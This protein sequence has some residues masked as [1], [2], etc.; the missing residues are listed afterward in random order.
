[1][2]LSVIIPTYNEEAYIQRVLASVCQEAHDPPEVIVV[3]CGS[4]DHT[5]T[6]AR[7]YPVT[8]VQ[9]ASLRGC[10]WKSLNCG[11][12]IARGDVLLFLDADS[13]VP[14]HFD[15]IIQRSL[16]RPNVVGGAFELAFDEGGISLGIILLIN[17]IRYRFRKRFYG[18]QGI[19]I[20]SSVFVKMGGWPALDIMEAAYFCKRAQTFGKLRLIT[21]PLTT[22]ARRFVEGGVWR[23]FF[24]DLRV[25]ALHFLGFNVQHFAAAYWQDNARR[26]QK[27]G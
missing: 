7:Q 4:V 24:H 1:M 15:K 8:I 21:Q 20:K 10:K 26:G 9:D 16:E 14:T 25:W 18:D 22:S 11:A 19:F 12:A 23:V 13:V 17:R 3:D 5:I 2:Q 6:L 27:K